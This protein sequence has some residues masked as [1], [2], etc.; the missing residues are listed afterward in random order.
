MALGLNGVCVIGHGSS[1]ARAV[2]NAVRVA[3]ELAQR[4]L[5]SVLA[6]AVSPAAAKSGPAG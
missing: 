1:S 5:P 2:V 6:A 3:S 4:A